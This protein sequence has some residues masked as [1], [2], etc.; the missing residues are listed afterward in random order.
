M[1]QE[2]PVFIVCEK[3]LTWLKER[4]DVILAKDKELRADNKALQAERMNLDKA[5]QII[6]FLCKRMKLLVTP[7]TS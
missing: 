7:P 2:N 3:P 1:C 6:M 4:H 5:E